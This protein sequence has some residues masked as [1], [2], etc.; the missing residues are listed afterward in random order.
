V[1]KR[2]SRGCVAASGG[3]RVELAAKDAAVVDSTGAGDALAAGF[4]LGGNLHQA[5]ERSLAAAA[6]WVGTLGA[7]P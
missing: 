3:N 7:M 4:L 6:R 2:G 5:A 1:L